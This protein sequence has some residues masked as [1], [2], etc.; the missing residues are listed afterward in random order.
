[1]RRQ[2]QYI[3]MKGKL[4]LHRP[5]NTNLR[6]L[7]ARGTWGQTR[8]GWV[9][10]KNIVPRYTRD[11]NAMDTSADCTRVRLANAE[12]VLARDQ[13]RNPH[14]PFPPRGGAMG[15]RRGPHTDLR[16]VVC[17]SCGRK[18][19]ISHQCPSWNEPRSS[20]LHV[21]TTQSYE[22]DYEEQELPKWEEVRAPPK[23]RAAN[24]LAGVA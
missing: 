13:Q 14:P 11:P 17:Y 1:M 9:P 4:D 24:W 7:P 19:H 16:E 22:T 21:N 20:Q 10:S 12:Y 18:G 5:Q 23:Q 2:E 6:L 8:G 15:I 3:H